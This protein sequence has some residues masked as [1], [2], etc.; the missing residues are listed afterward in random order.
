[1]VLCVSHSLS[2]GPPRRAKPTGF[3]RTALCRTALHRIAPHRT[4]PIPSRLATVTRNTRGSLVLGVGWF[5]CAGKLCCVINANAATAGAHPPARYRD[6]CCLLSLSC[7]SIVDWYCASA[8]VLLSPLPGLLECD[9]QGS[10]GLAGGIALPSIAESSVACGFG[11]SARRD[12]ITS[13][14]RLE[15]Y[16]PQ[17]SEATG[18]TRLPF[19]GGKF[20]QAILLVREWMLV[21]QTETGRPAGKKR[22]KKKKAPPFTR[23]GRVLILLLLVPVGDPVIDVHRQNARWVWRI[24]PFSS[25]HV[26]RVVDCWESCV[27]ILDGVV[28]FIGL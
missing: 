22:G 26:H 14:V 23:T 28:C 24:N 18:K 7:A 25:G 21:E 11:S 6:H 20:T 19:F 15:Y 1:M 4:H 27:L 9:G 10:I 3:L 13:T 16:Y 17:G 5:F 12:R 2:P 8:I